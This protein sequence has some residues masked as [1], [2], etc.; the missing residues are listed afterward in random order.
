MATKKKLAEQVMRVISGGHI[1][2]DRTIDIREVMLFIDQ[3]RDQAAKISVFNNIKQGDYSIDGDF[4]TYHKD[5]TIVTDSDMNLRYMVLPENI[6]A[7]PHDLGIYMISPMQNQDKPFHR[8]QGVGGGLYRG[9]QSFENENNTYYWNIGKNVYFKNVDVSVS[10]LLVA[11]VE[12]SQ[13][14][15][16]SAEYPMPPDLE[17][18]VVQRA[19]EMFGVQK[20]IPHDEVEDGQ[21]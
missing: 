20:Q 2:P 17:G 1:K 14:I 11:L 6:L 5:V 4:I 13:S 18:E 8:I 16:E 7:L 10:E 12:T 3:L 19:I 21:K 15:T 9:M